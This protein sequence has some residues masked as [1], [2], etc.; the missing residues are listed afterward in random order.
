MKEKEIRIEELLYIC[1]FVL[2]LFAKGIGLYDGQILY[3]LIL[4]IALGCV[5]IKMCITEHTVQE[6]G[7]I[8]LLGILTAV[9]YWVSKEKGIILCMATVIAIKNV[10]IKKVFKIGVWTWGITV[11]VNLMFHLLFWD[12]SGYKVHEKLGLGHIFRWDLGFSHPNVLHITYLTL[13]AFI[14]YNLGSRC[15]LKALL[16]LMMG[17]VFIFLYSVSYTGIIAVTLYLCI[18]WYVCIRKNLNKFEYILLEMVFPICLLLSFLAPVILPEKIFNIVNKIFST[19]LSLA[20]YFLV[21]ENIKLFGNNLADIT[22]YQYTMDN[23]YVFSFV[24]YGIIFFALLVIGY[25]GTIHECVKQKKNMELAMLVAFLIAGITE[26]FMFNTSFKNLTLLFVGEWLWQVLK[27]RNAEEKTYT[28][29]KNRTKYVYIGYLCFYEMK[30]NIVKV[31]NENK[32]SFLIL[33]SILGIISAIVC[34]VL[35]EKPQGYIV[36]RKHVDIESEETWYLESEYEVRY[37]DYIII[38]Y[39]SPATKMQIFEGN[40]VMVEKVRSCISTLIIT[41]LLCVVICLTIKM[42]RNYEINNKR[43]KL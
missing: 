32:K 24:I 19:R 11:L 38:D 43:K 41:M 33:S 31:W 12:M 7:A 20:R 30:N 27:N 18:T 4:V 36:P 10:S 28:L 23:S 22:T 1:F 13:V 5:A 14:I 39:E 17:N 37:N 3:K 42:F 40:I 34:G 29:I 8:V 15:N 26:P 9:I 35:T 2:M 25:G 6:W 16:L 21:E